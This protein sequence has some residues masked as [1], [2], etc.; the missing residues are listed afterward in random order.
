[1]SGRVRYAD[2]GARARRE[3]SAKRTL[4]ELLVRVSHRCTEYATKMQDET[5]DYKGHIA[6]DDSDEPDDA[7]YSLSLIDLPQAWNE[8]AENG[9]DGRIPFLSASRS[10]D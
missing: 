8:K 5:R 10:R 7:V 9:C 4:S 6:N 1:M 2:Q 3:W